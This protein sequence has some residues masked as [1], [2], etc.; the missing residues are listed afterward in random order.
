MLCCKQAWDE[1]LVDPV[2]LENV[3]I[4]GADVNMMDIITQG[5]EMMKA[6]D[7]KYFNLIQ[8][9]ARVL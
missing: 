4:M 3:Q 2:A 7:G 1:W 9:I 6:E 5:I 8:L